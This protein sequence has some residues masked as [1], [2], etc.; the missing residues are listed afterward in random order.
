MKNMADTI[1][2]SIGGDLDG[3]DSPIF[4]NIRIISKGS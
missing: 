3:Q 1:V 4:K 2:L